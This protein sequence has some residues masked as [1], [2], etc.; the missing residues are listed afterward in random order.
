MGDKDNGNAAAKANGDYLGYN[1]YAEALWSRIVVALDKDR[2]GTDPLGDDPLVV[3]IFGEWGAGKS[4]LLKLVERHATQQAE[5]RAAWRKHEGGNVSLTVPVF[6]QPWKYEH[7]P[8]LHVPILLHILAALKRHM[9][10]AQIP[11][12]WALDKL[13]DAISQHMEAVVGAFGKLLA[14]VAVAMDTTI[15]L[16]SRV[17]LAGAGLLA[18]VLPKVNPDADKK[19]L[20][21]TLEYKKNGRFFYEMHET[22]Q[23]ITRPQRYAKHLTGVSLRTEVSINFVIFI[24]DLDRC[25]PEKAVEALELIKTIFN[26]ESFAFVL[27]LDEEVVERGIGHRY[28]DYAMVNKKPEMPITGF[29]YLEKIVHLPFRLP[30]LTRDQ[31]RQFLERYESSEVAVGK[32]KR[33]FAPRPALSA[34]SNDSDAEATRHQS[35]ERRREVDAELSRLVLDAF[36]AYVPRKLVRL[37]ELLHQVQEVAS[38]RDRTLSVGVGGVDGTDVRVVTAL[39]MLQLFQPDL[40]RLVRRKPQAFPLLLAAFATR[41]NGQP[42][43]AD[44]AIS[45]LD[46]WLWVVDESAGED[47]DW[48]QAAEP[49]RV[50]DAVVARIAR[51]PLV[52]ADQNASGD[53][54]SLANRVDLVGTREQRSRALNVKL[55]LVAQ[56]VE[57]R[58]THRHAFDPLRLFHALAGALET[59]WKNPTQ[60]VQ[61]AGVSPA[62]AVSI[63]AYFELMVARDGA[64]GTSRERMR[65]TFTTSWSVGA[66]IA[67]QPVRYP[68]RLFADITSSQPEVQANLVANN[69]LEA[70]KVLELAAAETLLTQLNAWLDT[71]AKNGSGKPVKDRERL[72]RGLRFIAPFVP[73]ELG[74][75]Y[76]LLVDDPQNP[77]FFVP[78]KPEAFETTGQIREAFE[79]AELWS[80]LGQDD[81]F[82]PARFHLPKTR[83]PT[84]SPEQEPVVGFVRVPQGPFTLGAKGSGFEDNPRNPNARIDSDFYIARYPT[85]VDQYAHFITAG[86]YGEPDGAKPDWWDT[87]GWQWR[88]GQWDSKVTD[89]NYRK[90]LASRQPSLRGAPMQWAEQRAHG[91][92]PVVGLCWF[93]ARAYARWLSLQLRSELNQRLPGYSVSLPT[94][95]QW[96]R[97]ARAKDATSADERPYPWG[98]HPLQTAHLHANIR[99]S[100]LKRVSPVGLFAPNPLGLCDLSGNVW[101]WQNN[102]YQPDGSEQHTGPG[103]DV[104][105]MKTDDDW[106]KADCPS[107]RGGSWGVTADD[108]RASFRNWDPPDVWYV[109]V[110]FRVVLSL[111]ASQNPET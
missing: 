99:V 50:Q 29:E 95:A 2:Q 20:A 38:R 78:G 85:T 46:L 90:H 61:P 33:W 8:H 102:L 91:S 51:K 32:L 64:D 18:K 42:Q 108:A 17:G 69:E 25:L 101:E 35:M 103:S 47:N 96:E 3:G 71:R 27:A 62:A 40:Y 63:S 41:E 48:L 67:T 28:R 21:K 58:A 13:R 54:T 4:T 56:I 72:T 106:Q 88:N 81:R 109:Y 14:A 5:Q 107:L 49:A 111:A 12:E 10:Q 16:S 44:P 84:H 53:I 94:E 9:E 77:P 1:V 83:W 68:D 100:G 43:I 37:V 45:D 76:L 31:A 15:P 24:D 30:G 6:F 97:A 104:T 89:E 87:L 80:A 65:A 52:V 22:L 66:T 34:G 86:G 74:L 110:G 36:T 75:R 92:R 59:G 7:E 82:D 105:R 55:P 39:V 11:T 79:H 98:E 93:E 19:E 60:A 73:R 23:A 70:G 57:H 26:L